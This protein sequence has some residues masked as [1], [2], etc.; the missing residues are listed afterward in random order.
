MSLG[1]RWS[2]SGIG[3]Q[4]KSPIPWCRLCPAGLLRP[5]DDLLQGTDFALQCLDSLARSGDP[6]LG[7]ASLVSL[8]DAHQASGLQY[9]KVLR[10]VSPGQSASAE[11][12]GSDVQPAGVTTC[13]D[14][15][16][17]LVTP[18]GETHSVKVTLPATVGRSLAVNRLPSTRWFQ[19]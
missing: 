4:T 17:F 18:P 7:T 16:A 9:L 12:E 13:V 15:P 5:G 3:R 11:I 1:H 6:R 14:Y 19:E 2:V 10:E 8:F